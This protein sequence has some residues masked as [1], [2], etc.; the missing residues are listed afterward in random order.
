MD[1]MTLHECIAILNRFEFEFYDHWKIEDGLVVG[2]G[3][4]Q[5][6]SPF[7]AKAIARAFL[8]GDRPAPRQPNIEGVTLLL[9]QHFDPLTGRL[10]MALTYS[11]QASA[12]DV[13]VASRQLSYTTQGA[14][15]PISPATVV[16]L[17]VGIVCNP[18]DAVSAT[19]TD[20]GTDGV[21]SLPSPA[22]TFTAAAGPLPPPPPVPVTP[23]ITGVT[24][25]S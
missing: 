11:V 7:I 21:A 14:G 16:D 10:T 24:Q 5:I 4:D 19:L 9:A 3:F 8:N 13:S 22:F 12:A 18:L 6:L 15:T 25:T 20:T 17:S 23:T 2:S 1:P